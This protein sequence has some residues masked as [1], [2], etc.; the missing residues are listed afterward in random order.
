MD[1]H[2]QQ[3]AHRVWKKRVRRIE[4]VIKECLV[5]GEE[6]QAI[7]ALLANELAQEP[8]PI[9]PQALLHDDVSV[10]ALLRS[11]EQWPVSGWIVDEGAVALSMLRT[12]DFP[13]LANLSSGKV[14]QHGR[15]DE[16]RME[17]RGFLTT[18]FMVQPSLFNTFC[19]KRGDELKASGLDARFLYHIVL[20]K[21]TGSEDPDDVKTGHA[22]EQYDEHVTAMLDELDACIR[23]GKK[24][25]SSVALSRGAKAILREL[26]E[27]NL[28]LM[29][30]PD[31]AHCRDF[32]AKLTGHIARMA[33]K[34][35]VFLG[36][37]G[38]VSAELVEMA[39]QVCWYHFEAY[40][41]MHNPLEQ[42]PRKVRDAA[43][44]VQWMLDHRERQFA[45]SQISKVA[46]VI[47]MTVARLRSAIGELF[48]QGRARMLRL[49]GEDYIELLPPR[50]HLERILGDVRL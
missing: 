12:K 11:L 23:T 28:S 45:Y 24:D 46:M 5:N 39:E 34:N 13:T 41:W 10:Q 16:P 38:D 14:I 20:D 33:A 17:I 26:Q 29:A 22:H 7:E 19:K 42:E 36:C 8:R 37:E 3:A 4:D 25:P 1:R 48:H 47:G 18:L 9:V 2:Q 49:G 50:D 44:L 43:T 31:L 15:V 30:Q 6:T 27:R 35:H 32:L 21:W 40:Q